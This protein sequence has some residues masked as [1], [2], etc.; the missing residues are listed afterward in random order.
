[1]TDNKCCPYSFY[2]PVKDKDLCSFIESQSNLSMSIRL[3]LKAFIANYKDDYPDITTMDLKELINATNIET[4]LDHTPVFKKPVESKPTVETENRERVVDVGVADK[5]EN[6]V[7]NNPIADENDEIED[8]KNENADDNTIDMSVDNILNDNEDEILHDASDDTD[9]NE[10]PDEPQKA[11][12]SDQAEQSENSDDQDDELPVPE[13]S[14][15]VEVPQKVI[16]STRMAYHQG[17]TGEDNTGTI[18]DI[19]GSDED[20][21]S[22]LGNYDF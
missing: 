19:L 2:V 15:E 9:I 21:D 8:V 12:R 11:E 4:G 7:D 3:L 13:V 20:V 14:R 10:N 5:N 16:S 6:V 18:N 17:Q 22:M 1:M